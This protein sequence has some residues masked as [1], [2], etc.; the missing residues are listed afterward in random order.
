MR[1]TLTKTAA[2]LIAMPGLT[3]IG[4]LAILIFFIVIIEQTYYY[5]QNR[6]RKNGAKHNIQMSMWN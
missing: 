6:R 1:D 2:W 5:C 3:L 4:I